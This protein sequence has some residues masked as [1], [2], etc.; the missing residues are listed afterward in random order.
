M[1][2]IFY[3]VVRPL[4]YTFFIIVYKPTYVGLENVPKDGGVVLAGNHTNNFDCLALIATTKR[5]IHFLGKHTLFKGV[6]RF[7]FEG[8]GVIPVDRTKNNNHEAMEAAIDVLRGGCVVGIFPEGTINRT[9]EVVIPF[10]MGAVKMASETDSPIIPFAI[11]GSY[12]PFKKGLKIIF[13]EPLH[14]SSD[15]ESDNKNLS[16]EVVHLLEREDI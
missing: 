6:K 14:T 1:D 11:S 2:P 3:R 15:L 9:S 5:P 10:K 8:M 13:G 4:L 12:R 16:D 7:I